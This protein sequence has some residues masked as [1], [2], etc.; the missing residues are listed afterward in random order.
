MHVMSAVKDRFSYQTDAIKNTVFL[1]NWPEKSVF[2]VATNAA[3]QN[4]TKPS[5]FFSVIFL[6]ALVPLGKEGLV[7]T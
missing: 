6:F 1:K 7:K 2:L 4:T 5:Q 3:W